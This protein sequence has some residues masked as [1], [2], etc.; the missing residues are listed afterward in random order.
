M[1][2]LHVFVTIVPLTLTDV[3][4]AP[5]PVMLGVTK[6]VFKTFDYK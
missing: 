5:V 1:K 3:M 2:W 6:E 4:E